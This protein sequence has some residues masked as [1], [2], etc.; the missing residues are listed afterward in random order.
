MADVQ[1]TSEVQQWLNKV[2]KEWVRG[3]RFGPYSGTQ[4]NSVFR[5][6]MDLQSKPGVAV[7]V[8]MIGKLS[9]AGVTG[10]NTLR[11]NEEAP[12]NW[13]HQVNT[14]QYRNAIRIGRHE[15]AKSQIQFLK[16]YGSLL[17]AWAMEHLRDLKIAA[18]LS[19]VVDGVTAYASAT[20]AQ[21][22]A[23]TDAQYTSATNARVLFGN[24]ISNLS[25]SAPAGGATNDHSASLDAVDSSNDTLDT[26][27]GQLAKRMAQTASRAIQPLRLGSPNREIFVMFCPPRAFRDLAADT[28]MTQANR[29]ARQRGLDNPIFKG[30]DLWHDGVLY[31]EVPEIATLSGVGNGSIDVDPCFLCGA[32]SVGVAWK[33]KMHFIE[34]TQDFK[35]LMA[36]GV[37]FD[38]GVE[39]LMWNNQQNGQVTV[40]ASGVADS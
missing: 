7:N 30:G 25:Q 38:Y 20:E 35:N 37:A 15:Q 3:E 23:W 9:N 27:M 16:E 14:D 24:A 2:N 21:K 39:K 34:E 28:T 11:N 26:G 31:V 40:Y 13:N 12:S 17:Q 22:D 6:I 19:P 4:Q 1:V 18:M 8:P 5:N 10:D 32:L 29:D 33:E 36:R